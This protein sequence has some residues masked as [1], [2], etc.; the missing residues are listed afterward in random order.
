M[1][2]NDPYAKAPVWDSYH[3]MGEELNPQGWWVPNLL[4][5]LTTA[6]ARAVLDVGW[7]P[8]GYAVSLARSGLH[9]TA[10]D[11]SEGALARARAEGIASLVAEEFQ[12]RVIC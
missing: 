3:A 2:T 4:P 12:P 5:F 9:G 1:R 10:M 8:G 6:G 11:Y 7:G